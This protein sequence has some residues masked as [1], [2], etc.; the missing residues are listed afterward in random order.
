MSI[1]QRAI[2]KFG[3]AAQ[4][5]QAIEECSELITSLLHFKRGKCS[6]ADVITEIADVSIMCEQLKIMFGRDSVDRE[7]E[8]KLTRLEINLSNLPIGIIGIE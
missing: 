8:S 6:Q 3:Y 4:T 2:D 7:I 5:N 1:Y